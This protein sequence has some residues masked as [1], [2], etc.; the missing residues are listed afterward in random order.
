MKHPGNETMVD[1]G[2]IHIIGTMIFGAK[3]LSHVYPMFHWASPHFEV[4]KLWETSWARTESAACFGAF[5]HRFWKISGILNHIT[6]CIPNIMWVKQYWL[7]V[8]TPLKNIRNIS[9]LGWLL[10]NRWTNK[11]MFQTTNQNNKPPIW[12]WC[13][14]PPI[15]M[16]IC[17]WNNAINTHDWE[18]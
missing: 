6:G 7:V 3:G 15:K 2:K 17:G 10:Q 4:R 18:W 13:N 16:V 1:V 12:E 5:W 8:W 11:K 14:K 9:Q